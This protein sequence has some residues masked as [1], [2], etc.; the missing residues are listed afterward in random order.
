MQYP[1]ID[2]RDSLLDIRLFPLNGQR[3]LVIHLFELLQKGWE[4]YFSIAQGTFLAEKTNAA[5]E[6][7]MSV[8][9]MNREDVGTQDIECGERI[10]GGIHDHVGWIEIDLQIL[11]IYVMDK[12]EQDFRGFLSGFQN[13]VLIMTSTVVAKQFG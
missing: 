3:T 2:I 6:R 1:G 7:K 12:C 11:P 8:L 10:A 5:R 13:K 4:I 9:A